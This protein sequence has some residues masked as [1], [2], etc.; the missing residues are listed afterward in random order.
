MHNSRN[1]MQSV[2]GDG[3]REE[4]EEV[5]IRRVLAGEKNE[6]RHLVAR[7]QSQVYAMMLRQVGEP[8]LAEELTQ[9]AFLRAYRYLH[10]FRFESKFSTW[11]IRIALNRSRSYFSSKQF[12]NKQRLTAL[13]MKDLEN[14][15]VEETE[16]SE[17]TF[18]REAIDRLRSAIQLLKPKFR[19]VLVLCALEKKSYEETAEVLGVKV[20]TVRS[21]LFRARQQLRDLYFEV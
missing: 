4:D 16:D 6:F 20:G 17:E 19:E 14:R 18:S 11:I 9:D 8:Q 12:K 21:R 13:D 1:V 5:L 15:S 3:Q 7:Y 10:S 2:Q